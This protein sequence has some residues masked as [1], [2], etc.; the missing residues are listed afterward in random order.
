MALAIHLP[1]AYSTLCP[2][3]LLEAIRGVY[4]VGKLVSCELWRPGPNDTYILTGCGGRYMLRAYGARRRSASHVRYELDLIDHLAAQGLPV[5]RPIPGQDG[6]LTRAVPAPEGPRQVALLTFPEG[7]PF[8]WSEGDHSYLAGKALARIHAAS[9]D[10]ASRNPRFTLDLP[11]L[12]DAPLAALEPFLA[13]RPE[14]WAFL[15]ALAG[16]LEA[17]AARVTASGLDW[18]VCHGDFS[19]GCL[20]VD[21][22]AALTVFDFDPCGPG[23]R[24]YELA[25]AQWSWIYHKKGALWDSFLKGYNE[26]RRL[27]AAD[28]DALPLFHMISRLWRLGMDAVNADQWGAARLRDSNLDYHLQVFREWEA[29]HRSLI[30][31]R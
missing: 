31:G 23:W 19:D 16:R 18:G 7:G 25:A 29:E 14:D 30:D 20:Q 26:I 12:I 10:F 22:G 17:A 15:K 8:V 3:G 24:A 2:E 4:P 6:A 1:A 28:L 9:A 13:H 27:A 21:Q 5:C 11:Y